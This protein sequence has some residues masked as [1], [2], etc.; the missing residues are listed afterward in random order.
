MPIPIKLITSLIK[1]AI[2]LFVGKSGQDSPLTKNVRPI[3]VGILVTLIAMPRTN[4]PEP[5]RPPTTNQQ[6]AGAI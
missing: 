3:T 1:P 2:G 6:S 4:M 5:L